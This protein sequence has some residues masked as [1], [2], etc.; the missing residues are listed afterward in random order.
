MRVLI[1]LASTVL[2]LVT[3][4]P[5]S[6]AQDQARRATCRSPIRYK[7][8]A[9]D[10]RF[11]VT[12]ED[13]QRAAEDA[14]GVWATHQKLFQYDPRGKLRINLV[15]DTRQKNTQ[16]VIFARAGI[17]AKIK[18]ADSIEDRILSLQNKF[19]PLEAS[20]LE[21]EAS[22]DQ[23]SDNFNR[24]ARR[25]NDAGGASETQFQILSDKRRSLRNQ[26]AILEAKRQE[27]NRSTDEINGLVEKHNAL[28]VRANTE[29]NALNRSGSI[30]VQF[31]GGLYSRASGKEWIDIF[32]FESKAGLRVILAH[33]LGHALGMKHN[34]NPSSIMS[35]LIHTERL[36]LT[37]EDRD[38][39]KAVCGPP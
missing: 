23:A 38:S 35:P 34:A 6:H 3:T 27:L 18:E 15:Y 36:A 39:L 14:S 8:G 2:L 21:Q 26:R 5:F 1:I 7:I 4:A 31:E 16:Q 12:R 10:P 37:G 22:Y 30:G 17:S 9:L 29:A 20:Y 25:L 28:L 24:E 19:Q 32:Q 11:G 13:L 33:E